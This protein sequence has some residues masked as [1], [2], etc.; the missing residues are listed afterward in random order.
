MA[1]RIYLVPNGNSRNDIFY[2]VDTP[3]TYGYQTVCFT[4]T[5]LI[6]HDGKN[7]LP[8]DEG[9]IVMPLTSVSRIVKLKDK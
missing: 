6:L 2:Y 1:H 5:G 4:P 3:L 8:D 7:I 9:Y